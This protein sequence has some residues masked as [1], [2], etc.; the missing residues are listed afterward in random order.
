MQKVENRGAITLYQE[1]IHVSS[2]SLTNIL[3]TNLEIIIAQWL[4]CDLEQMCIQIQNRNYP[5]L[6]FEGGCNLNEQ[7][8][9]RVG[10]CCMEPPAL[11][12]F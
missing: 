5:L 3:Q 6:L 9:D 7:V 1:S 12:D 11:R 2:S 8:W 10:V 4:S